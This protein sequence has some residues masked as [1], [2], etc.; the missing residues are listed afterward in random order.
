MFSR[1]VEEVQDDL[2][3]TQALVKHL[4]QP[5]AEPSRCGMFCLA[6]PLTTSAR[7]VASHRLLSGSTRTVWQS[8]RTSSTDV[9]LL[10][11]CAYLTW[12]PP[13]A[14]RA[15]ASRLS[16]A[17]VPRDVLEGRATSTR[18][19]QAIT[20][21]LVELLRRSCSRALGGP[22]KDEY[23]SYLDSWLKVFKIDHE[24]RGRELRVPEHDADVAQ[25]RPGSCCSPFSHENMCTRPGFDQSVSLLLRRRYT[26][27]SSTRDRIEKHCIGM[28]GCTKTTRS[29]S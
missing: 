24:S 1:L 27:S 2:D 13:Q 20:R 5:G 10:T 11:T 7:A 19:Y 15:R 16:A 21:S 25:S 8:S 23:T 12:R 6:T 3:R 17:A 4:R 14:Q 18:V 28:L 9:V 22:F 29:R 26:R